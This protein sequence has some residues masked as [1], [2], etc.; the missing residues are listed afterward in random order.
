MKTLLTLFVLLFSFSLVAD[1]ISDF[2][3]EG[4]SIGDS[5]LDYYSKAEI[6]NAPNYND[7]PSDMKFTIVEMPKKGKYDILQIFYYTNDINYKIASIGG[8]ISMDI[9]KCIKEQKQITEDISSTLNNDN[10]SGPSQITNQDDPSGESYYI[11]YNLY[12]DGGNAVI[13]CYHFSNQVNWQDNMR[14]SI[15]NHEAAEWV[16][17]NYGL[18]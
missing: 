9:D 5:L 12:F 13:D 17:R 10:V 18:N 11:R 3:I 7:L 2:E 4:I 1:D 6:N 16:D 15:I 14:I 8:G